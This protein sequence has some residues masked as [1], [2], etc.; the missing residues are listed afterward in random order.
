VQKSLS[1]CIWDP[2][3]VPFDFAKFDTQLPLHI[4]CIALSMFADE[5]GRQPILNS[6]DDV[7]MV[8]AIAQ[9]I[10]NEHRL[11]KNIDETV[12]PLLSLELSP[13]G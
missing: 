13:G 9:R 1:E 7:R 8:L 10:N 11:I 2:E 6:A 12:L 5:H 3:I 4:G